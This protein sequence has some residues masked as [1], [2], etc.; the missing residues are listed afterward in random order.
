M[1]DLDHAAKPS[2]LQRKVATAR[3]RS[4]AEVDEV[5]RELRDFLVGAGRTTL[6]WPEHGL[7]QAIRKHENHQ[8]YLRR[9][10]RDHGE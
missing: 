9:Q 10:G 2:S 6:L 1:F 7:A 8:A 4:S 3:A 5:A